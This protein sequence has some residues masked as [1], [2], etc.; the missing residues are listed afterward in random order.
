MERGTVRP[1]NRFL[2]ASLRSLLP[3]AYPE[4]VQRG[5]R[6]VSSSLETRETDTILWFVEQVPELINPRKQVFD[7]LPISNKLVELVDVDHADIVV[8]LPCPRHQ[9][10]ENLGLVCFVFVRNLP[11]MSSDETLPSLAE[12]SIETVWRG[13]LSDLDGESFATRHGP[14]KAHSTGHKVLEA[15]REPSY[16]VFVGLSRV[17]F[18]QVEQS[19]DP[20][21]PSRQFDF[22]RAPLTTS[23]RD[24]LD[25]SR[26]RCRKRRNLHVV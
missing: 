4:N 5:E 22:A 18:E 15:H 26:Q 1:A 19:F 14:G 24:R 17:V 25:H 23:T 7:V 9:R 13:E 3:L 16:V 21:P 6:V 12:V 8:E 20:A 11:G 2:V 10:A